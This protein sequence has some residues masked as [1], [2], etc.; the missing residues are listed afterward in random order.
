MMAC[1]RER[2]KMIACMREGQNDSMHEGED[3]EEGDELQMKCHL[4][5]W[6]MR[7]NLEHL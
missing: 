1:M 5:N 7:N 2:G 4:W 3:E 6:T